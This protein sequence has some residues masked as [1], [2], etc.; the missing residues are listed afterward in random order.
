MEQP[1]GQYI[2]ITKTKWILPWNII[3]FFTS[4]ESILFHGFIYAFCL[5][6]KIYEEHFLKII[7]LWEEVKR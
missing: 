2:F 4:K 1:R 5:L 3:Y 7:F 6:Y